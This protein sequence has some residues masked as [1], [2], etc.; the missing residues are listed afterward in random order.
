MI[1]SYTEQLTQGLAIP[2]ADLP[3]ANY[4]NNTTAY[5]VGPVLANEFTRFLGKISV[6]VITGAANVSG[7]LQSCNTSNGTFANI[8]TTNAVCF[9]STSN[10]TMTVE[11]RADQLPST[12]T[13]YVQLAVLVAANSAFTQAELFGAG[14]RYSPASQYTLNTTYVKQQTVY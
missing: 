1:S 6:G 14:S 9:S 2:A 10:T 3:P 8:S 7:Y 13:T 5:T 4:A 11:C 12:Q